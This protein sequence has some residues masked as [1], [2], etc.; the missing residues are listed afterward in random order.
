M[1]GELKVQP[2][3]DSAEFIS[4]F[5]TLYFD[6]K[7]DKSV[8]ILD[9]R[10]HKTNALV[11]IDGINTVDQ[12]KSLYGKILYMKR[13]DVALGEGVFF[14]DDILGCDVIDIDTEKNYGVVTDVIQTGANDVYQIRDNNKKDY[15]IPVIDDVVIE[16]RV[17]DK[18]IYIRPIKGIFE[19]EN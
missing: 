3:C 11:V 4:L 16:F 15:L 14:I 7:G 12:A 1:N 8:K 5:D 19:D 18:K 9:S 10:P 2:W 13:S 17:P 6:S